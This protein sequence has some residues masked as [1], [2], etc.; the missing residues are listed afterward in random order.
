M[1][2]IFLA[3]FLMILP[4]TGGAS[5]WD[6]GDLINAVKRSQVITELFMERWTVMQNSVSMETLAPMSEEVKKGLNIDSKDKNKKEKKAKDLNIPEFSLA[7]KFY[8][9]N[10][11]GFSKNLDIA[12]HGEDILGYNVNTPFGRYDLTLFRVFGSAIVKFE[13]LIDFG[14]T[15]WGF[16]IGAAGYRYGMYKKTEL[17]DSLDTAHEYG[18]FNV[19]DYLYTQVFDDLIVFTNIFKGFGYVHTGILMNEQVDPGSD[20]M[21]NTADDKQ[22]SSKAR[23]FFDS[24]ILGM[25]FANLGYNSDSDKAEYLSTKTEIFAL[26]SVFGAVEKRALFPDL[27][28]GYTYNNPAVGFENINLAGAQIPQSIHTLFMDIHYTYYNAFY[29]KAKGEI[30]LS[31]QVDQENDFLF[32]QA[33]G[34]LGL[35]FDTFDIIGNADKYYGDGMSQ[36]FFSYYFIFGMSYLVNQR[37]MDFGNDTPEVIGFSLGFKMN[38][39]GF[40]GGGSVEGKISRNYSEKLNN[41][42]EAYDHWIIELTLQIGF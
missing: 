29:I 26:L 12:F 9:I 4:L 27:S 15:Q 37:T 6:P 8:Y 28:I 34:E 21:V 22:I 13:D 32:R 16:A 23:L 25:L 39:A 18:K 3:L 20:G 35:R 40:F 36:F 31:G 14:I 19:K 7:E 24:N 33:Y 5:T 1:K 42:I 38:F 30:F 17:N 2:K 10:R 41:L 11:G